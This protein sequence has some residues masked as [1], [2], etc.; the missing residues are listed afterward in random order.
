MATSPR[1]SVDYPEPR[2]CTHNP[3]VNSAAPNFARP[4]SSQ[5]IGRVYRKEY[6]SSI[7][8]VVFERGLSW[9]FCWCAAGYVL[10][11]VMT[12][13]LPETKGKQ[14]DSVGAVVRSLSLRSPERSTRLPSRPSRRHYSGAQLMASPQAAANVGN[15]RKGHLPTLDRWRPHPN[16]RAAASCSISRLLLEIPIQLVRPQRMFLRQRGWEAAR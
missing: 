6:R 3:T 12:T 10:G 4:P 9:A 2:R 16:D 8:S 11:A 5:G 13:Q 7:S 15:N 14:L 1:R